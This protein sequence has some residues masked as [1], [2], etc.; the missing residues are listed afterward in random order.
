[1][2]AFSVT[3]FVYPTT[4]YSTPAT[5]DLAPAPVLVEDQIRK[6]KKHTDKKALNFLN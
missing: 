4:P 6:A 3:L 5:L 1:M 2:N